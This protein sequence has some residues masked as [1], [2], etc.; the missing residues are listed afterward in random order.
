MAC[1]HF[2][3]VTCL[4]RYVTL[5]LEE[6]VTL[7][8]CPAYKCAK[9]IDRV[10]LASLLPLATYQRHFRLAVQSVVT[11]SDWLQWCGARGCENALEGQPEG[12]GLAAVVQCHCG[13]VSCFSCRHEAHWPATCQQLQ[14]YNDT[15]ERKHA[16]DSQSEEKTLK[17][18]EQYTQDCPR[19]K[20]PIEKNGGCSHMNCKFCGAQFCWVCLGDWNGSHYNCTQSAPNRHRDLHARVNTDTRQMSFHQLYVMHDRSRTFDDTRIRQVAN[21]KMRG[22]LHRNSSARPEDCEAIADALEVIFLCRHICLNICVA[23]QYIH[24][25]E[26]GG[27]KQLKIIIG[28]LQ[29]NINLLSSVIDVPVKQLNIQMIQTLTN[30]AL[31]GIKSSEGRLTSILMKQDEMALKQNNNN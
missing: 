1:R 21:E 23:G 5:R 8:T 16:S 9:V 20:S 10:T 3:C 22:Y 29:H 28:K 2:Y 27:E 25:F 26:L 11:E 24:H 17:W 12:Q 19:C 30:S 31:N 4:T 14:W 15:H 13:F 7:L 6:N 18:L